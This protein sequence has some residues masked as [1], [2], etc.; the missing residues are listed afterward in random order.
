MALLHFL[1]A[2]DHVWREELL[3]AASS[4]GLSIPFARW[5]CEFLSNRTTRAQINGERG[6]SAPLRQGLPQGAVLSPLLFLLYIDDLRCV[7]LET[8][9]VALFADD[10]L[11]TVE[12]WLQRC[13]HAVALRHQLFGE[14]SPPLSVHTTNPGS[15]LALA[16]KTLL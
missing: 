5:L 16:R 4:K 14:P 11:R 15:V 8:V 1:K 10:E 3:L 12:N 13:R 2:F 6:D 7:V 9:K